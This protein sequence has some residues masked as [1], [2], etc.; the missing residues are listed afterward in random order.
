MAKGGGS[1]GRGRKTR[2]ETSPIPPKDQL[3]ELDGRA[4]VVLEALVEAAGGRWGLSGTQSIPGDA[5]AVLVE[6]LR[7][8][9]KSHSRPHPGTGRPYFP[10]TPGAWHAFDDLYP[11]QDPNRWN[12]LRRAVMLELESLGYERIGG[13]N[14]T[15]WYL[16]G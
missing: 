16:P 8:W 11:L 4:Q 2:E 14:G 3:S 15:T 7:A 10:G 13:A 9:M 5:K 6:L 1:L 12:P